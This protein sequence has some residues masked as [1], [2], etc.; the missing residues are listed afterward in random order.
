MRPAS[1]VG[2]A[3]TIRSTIDVWMTPGH[4]EFTR[5]PALAYS[6]AATF[7]SPFT[8]HPEALYAATPWNPT[9]PAIDAACTMAPPPPSTAG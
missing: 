7:V 4:T 9:S 1:I 2:L 5:M 3:A 8:P 6:M